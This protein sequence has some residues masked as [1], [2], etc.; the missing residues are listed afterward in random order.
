[1]R[2][3]LLCGPRFFYGETNESKT[4]TGLV[5]GRLAGGW[6]IPSFARL[7]KPSSGGESNS[8]F[9][10]DTGNAVATDR[11]CFQQKLASISKAID[12]YLQAK[13]P[14]DGKAA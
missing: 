6:R 7:P 9:G 2:G 8:K 5:E 10:H 12:Q 1:M 4:N 3:S 13:N 11:D 14:A